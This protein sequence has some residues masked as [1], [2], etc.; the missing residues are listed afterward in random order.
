[1]HLSGT[2]VNTITVILGSGLG[3]LIGGKLPERFKNTII[4]AI[5][6]FTFLIGTSMM[7]KAN[8][9][10]II[11]LAL[12]V[13]GIT[14]E[15]MKLEEHLDNVTER[16]KKHISPNSKNFTEG[17]ITATLIFCVGAMT[18]VGSI[19]EG[20]TGDATLL[21]TK[22]LMDGIT[23]LTL[24]SSLGIGVML[25]AVSIFVIQ[26]SLTLLGSALQFLMAGPYLNS[27]TSAGGLLIIALGIDLLQI[28]KLK[29]LN[30]LPS[31]FY[32]PLFVYVASLFH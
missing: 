9:L 18:V 31:L 25:S 16:L 13:G 24:A 7:L 11:F 15:A 32:A 14:G 29:V 4:Q 19:Q 3:L 5:A 6:L 8:N 2:I 10:I 17:F 23:S 12:I 26:G 27:I 21:Y 20:L 1:M 22:A 30:L 28:K